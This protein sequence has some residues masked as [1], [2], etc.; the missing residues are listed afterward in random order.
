MT[1][2]KRNGKVTIE[3]YTQTVEAD[4]VTVR[5]KCHRVTDGER[6]RLEIILDAAGERAMV[7]LP[8]ERS[9]RVPKLAKQAAIGF[10]ASLALRLEGG[11]L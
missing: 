1:T 6:L 8:V 4:G 3:E 11:R 9:H 10:A 5:T 7:D 2:P